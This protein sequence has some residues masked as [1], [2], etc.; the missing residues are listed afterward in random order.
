MKGCSGGERT[1]VGLFCGD[2]TRNFWPLDYD[3]GSAS[4]SNTSRTS[5]SATPRRTASSKYDTTANGVVICDALAS[6]D[7]SG[8]PLDLF[9]VNNGGNNEFEILEHTPGRSIRCG[10]VC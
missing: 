4:F 7:C 6:S 8:E 2:F 5:A 3:L 10:T 9:E 1:C